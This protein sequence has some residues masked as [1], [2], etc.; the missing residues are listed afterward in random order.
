MSFPHTAQ[1]RAACLATLCLLF[2]GCG[3]EQRRPNATPARTG[4]PPRTL[5]FRAADGRRLHGRLI[6]AGGGAPGVVLIHGLYGR[7]DQW[8][9][10]IPDLHA[11]GFATLAYA[12]RS[13]HEP[14]EAVL[15]KDVAGA[16]HALARTAD[17]RRIALVGASVGGTTVAYVLGTQPRVRVRGGVALSALELGAQHRYRPHDLLL[18]TDPRER[19][20]AVNLKRDAHGQGTTIYVAPN[21]GHGVA[22][23]PDGRVRDKLIA[24]LKRVTR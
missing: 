2:A 18:I 3:S 6:P 22:L 10:L 5:R 19:A 9:P 13:R 12:S 15:A 16:V 7:I 20:N 8:D 11:A 17:P 23:L 14:D 1:M 4:P 24:W 21:V